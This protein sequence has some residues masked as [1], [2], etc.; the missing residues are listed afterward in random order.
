[1]TGFGFS[2]DSEDLGG[3]RDKT[4]V[5]VPGAGGG[6]WEREVWEGVFAARQV[7]AWIRNNG[8]DE[9]V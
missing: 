5:F 9:A 3:M 6:D 4:V 2:A 7:L 8:R 1:V